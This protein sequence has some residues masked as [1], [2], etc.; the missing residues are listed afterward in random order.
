MTTA[1]IESLVAGAAPVRRLSPSWM[2]ATQWMS[3]AAILLAVFSLSHSFRYNIEHC[4]RAPLWLAMCVGAVMTAALAAVAA[5][6]L[7][8]PGRSRLWAL[9]P[10]PTLAVWVLAVVTRDRWIETRSDALGWSGVADCLATVV[11]IGLPLGLA[12]AIMLRR[13]A[14]LQPAVT[15]LLGGIA[16]G[17][18]VSAALHIF[19]PLHATLWITLSNA[20]VAALF[21]GLGLL[22]APRLFAATPR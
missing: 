2:R 6:E 15:A 14:V 17:G 8:V 16:V 13:A 12:M 22:I 7:G 19:H 20:G 11:L 21:A 9:L 18:V 5:M 1:L 3:F 4:L 10:M